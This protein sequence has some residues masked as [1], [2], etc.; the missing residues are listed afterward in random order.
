[1][2]YIVHESELA[3]CS[4]K[5][6]IIFPNFLV[7]ADVAVAFANLIRKYDLKVKSRNGKVTVVSAGEIT[8]KDVQCSGKSET[9]KASADP[10]DAYMIEFYDYFHGVT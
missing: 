3:S 10:N 6:P 5:I 9:T 2:K 8:M 7:H 1:M 4:Q